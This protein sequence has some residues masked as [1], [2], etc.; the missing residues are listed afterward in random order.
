M[1]LK[2]KKLRG[3]YNKSMVCSEKELGITEEHE[4]ILLL[5]HSDD[6]VPGTPFS[7]VLGDVVLDI[8]LTPNLG[9]GF[10]ILGVAR[11]VAALLNKELRKPDYEPCHGRRSD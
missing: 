11:E 5:N 6:Y 9:H 3:I 4:G 8:E 2:G 10:S 7:D 1:T